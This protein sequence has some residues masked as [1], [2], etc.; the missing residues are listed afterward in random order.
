[1]QRLEKQRSVD[2][3]TEDDTDDRRAIDQ[4]GQREAGGADE[5]VKGFPQ[6]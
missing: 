4:A 6:N 3:Q 5:G 2:R 1:L